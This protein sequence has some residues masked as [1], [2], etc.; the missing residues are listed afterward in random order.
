MNDL[1][2][3]SECSSGCES[4]WTLYLEHSF[5][6]QNPSHRD[7]GREV[8]NEEER[9]KDEDEE[10]DLSMV[11]DA[12]SGPPHF[13]EDEIYG[14]KGC[15]YNAPIDATLPNN[16]TKRKKIKETRHRMGQEQNSFLDDTASSP[17][18][19]F[20]NNNCTLND[21]Q[22]SMEKILDFSQGYSTTHFEGRSAFQEHFGFF[23]SHPSG[24]Q[25]QQNRW[26][27]RKRLGM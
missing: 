24:N 12:S 6:S 22:A 9:E 19:N 10:E 15:F 11:S 7:H 3:G 4:G 18:F 2:G 14:N 8:F 25:L 13:H 16:S 17:L 20:P 27:E 23:Q 26:F 21:N 5:L 1:L